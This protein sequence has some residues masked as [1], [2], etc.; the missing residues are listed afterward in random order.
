MEFDGLLGLRQAHG[1]AF[2][3]SDLF[4]VCACRLSAAAAAAAVDGR[5]ELRPCEKVCCPPRRAYRRPGCLCDS[6]AAEVCGPVKRVY[7][8]LPTRAPT[9]RRN[10]ARVQSSTAGGS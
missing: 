1:M 2:G 8:M 6:G 3:K 10:L 4:M 9:L 7:V 5:P